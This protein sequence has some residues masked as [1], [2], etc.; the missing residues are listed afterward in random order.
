MVQV[1]LIKFLKDKSEIG[2]RKD[3]TGKVTFIRLMKDKP[4]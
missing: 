4:G 1:L 3:K 2:L